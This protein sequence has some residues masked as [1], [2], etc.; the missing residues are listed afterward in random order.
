MATS[1]SAKKGA[2][3]AHDYTL[4]AAVAVESA[5]PPPPG[6][7]AAG[8]GLRID[9]G[10][11]R[12]SS[13]DGGFQRLVA[14]GGW[15]AGGSLDR[16]RPVQPL[17]ADGAVAARSAVV[18]GAG[19]LPTVVPPAWPA[20]GDS[21][22]QRRPVCLGGP[23]GF[24]AFACVVDGLGPPG[25]IYPA[26]PSAR[27]WRARTDA[28]GVEGR[29][30]ATAFPQPAG[31]A[32]AAGS[33]AAELQSGTTARGVAAKNSGAILSVWP[34][35]SGQGRAAGEVSG[36]LGAAPRAQQWPDPVARPPAFC[37]RGGGGL[38][39]RTQAVVGGQGVR[40]SG[41]NFVG[42]AAGV[43]CW[44]TPACGR[45]APASDLPKEKSV[46]DVLASLCYPCPGLV[47]SPAL[48]PIEAERVSLLNNELK[49]RAKKYLVQTPPVPDKPK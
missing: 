15:P 14:D 8:G 17:F 46:T 48:S 18:A 7:G 5:A 6:P 32:T 29:D 45:C 33:L 26:R 31:A 21:R 22:G 23:R 38:Q 47:P 20:A 4:A 13:M 49:I 3:A 28:P 9:P 16:A 44:R 36:H 39:G 11:N 42:R 25:R 37:G 1:A 12:Q 41:G 24:V 19:G 35:L 34:E 40:V 27:Q 2:G 30:D 43:G 10:A